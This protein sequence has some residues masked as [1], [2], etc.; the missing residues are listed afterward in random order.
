MTSVPEPLREQI[1]RSTLD[2]RLFKDEQGELIG[3]GALLPER[4]KEAAEQ[5]AEEDAQEDGGN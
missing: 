5:A 2:N 3:P 1:R 4:A